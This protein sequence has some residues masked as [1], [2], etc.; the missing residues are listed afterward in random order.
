MVDTGKVLGKADVTLER[1]RRPALV[2]FFIRLFREKPLG[3]GGAVV[4]LFLFIVAIFA[5]FIAPYGMNEVNIVNRLAPPSAQ[6]LMGTDN[7]GRDL[8]SRI[9]FGARI[10]VIV[11]LSATSIT[12]AL[13]SIIGI[14][15]GFLGG[16][17]DLIVQRF[18]DGWMCLPSLFILLTVMSIVGRGL[19]QIIIVLGISI[20][21]RNSRVIR[22]AVIAIKENMYV[23]ATKAIGVPVRTILTRHILPNVVAPMIIVFTTNIGSIILIE[24]SLSFLGLG[25]PP[26]VPSLGS[27]LSTE[28]RKYMEVAPQLALWPG[29]ALALI[30]Y[31]VNMLGDAVRD[32]LD[33]RLRGGLGR[34]GGVKVKKIK[35]EANMT[36]SK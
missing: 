32:L 3:A 22:S 4:F 24:A 8:F 14:T 33:P 25:I 5:D 6:Y 23:T 30:V 18:V 26:G 36:G 19:P 13:S 20:G 1:K 34:Y 16:K 10:S 17:F 11:G 2:D 7:L 35:K 31:S 29:C 15:T 12:L 27:M 28:G 21:I 9:I